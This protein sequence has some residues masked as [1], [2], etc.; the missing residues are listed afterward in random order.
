VTEAA[1]TATTDLTIR[2]AAQADAPA[3]ADVYLAAFKSTY[4][5][6]L[7]HTDEE[8]RG[9]VAEEVVPG[10]ETWVAEI[11]GRVVAMMV[12]DEPGVGHLYVDPPWQR[13]GIGSRLMELAKQRRPGGLE[14][15]TVQVNDRAR[16]FYEGHGFAV[17]TLG[18]GS[19]N[20]EGQP[21]VLYRW[22]P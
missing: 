21:D 3:I 13:H 7:A 14:L 19:G 8:V 11:G 22:R 15:Y 17:A 9:W 6:P 10:L 5:F 12:L 16:R 18:D 2:R 1:A 20:E 4:D